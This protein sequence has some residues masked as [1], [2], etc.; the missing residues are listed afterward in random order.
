V[1]PAI[2]KEITAVCY[3]VLVGVNAAQVAALHTSSGVHAAI[4]GGTAVLTA[5]V[6]RAAVTPNVKIG[7]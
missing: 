1:K 7:A 5:V 6:N 2:Q 3:L 4:I